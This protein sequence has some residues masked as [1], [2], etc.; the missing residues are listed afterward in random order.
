MNNTN[1][2]DLED[3]FRKNI[4]RAGKIHCK[5]H[6]LSNDVA[7]HNVEDLS[8]RMLFIDGDH[9][10]RGVREDI[11]LFLQKVK[12]GGIIVFDDYDFLHFQGLV[13]EVNNF[14][15]KTKPKNVISLIE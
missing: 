6:K 4:R 13:K 12:P 14:I 15:K 3:N 11:E 2:S 7:I 10:A 8:L 9:T 5:T 1:L